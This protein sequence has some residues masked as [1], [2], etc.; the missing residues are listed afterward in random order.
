[1]TTLTASIAAF[2]ASRDAAMADIAILQP[3]DPFLD[4]AGE[5]LRG[6]IFLTENETGEAL[7]LRP[8]FTIPVCLAHLR[9][10]AGAKRYGY[11]GEVFRQ[12]RE[13]GSAFVQAG[14]ED[15]GARDRAA[16]DAR[17]VA[18]ALAL[19]AT[20]APN[21][22]WQAT[23]GDQSVFEAV[24]KALG[25]PR[26]WRKKLAR[27]FGTP[28]QLEA[29][30]A[31]LGAPR[32]RGNGNGNGNGNGMH[33]DLAKAVEKGDAGR[34]A[35]LIAARME[36][37][38]YATAASR[39]PDEIA[40]RMLEQAALDNARLTKDQIAELRD[41]LAIAVPLAD[42]GAALRRFAKRLDGSMDGVLDA[43]DARAHEM[44]KQGIDPHAVVYNAAF[45]RSLDY[46]TGLVYEIGV[47]DAKAKPVVGG[48]RYDRLLTLLGAKAEVPGVGFSVWLDRL[49]IEAARAARGKR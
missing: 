17:S 46:Y 36:G 37:F 12:R 26:G 27:A 29:L 14:I 1:M 20:T 13:G 9:G 19:L 35:T 24:I 28:D 15:L 5:G 31:A 25:L 22:R 6:R 48:G 43:F 11:C 45:G 23:L 3:A 41:F 2:L 7:C 32:G 42:A 33:G 49:E 10:G 40:A 16:A 21:V 34:L 38:G 18:D 4:T 30:I 44:R 39:T 47:A 8:E